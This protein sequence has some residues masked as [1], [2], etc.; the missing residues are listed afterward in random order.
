MPVP[1]ADDAYLWL[2]VTNRH[3]AEGKGGRVA[4][5]WGFR[6][7]TIMTWCKTKMGLGHYLRNATEHVIFGVKGSPGPFNRRNVITH[8]TA[9]SDRHSS[10]PLGFVGVVETLC[11]GPYLELFARRKRKDWTSWGEAVGDPL[12]IGF[13]PKGWSA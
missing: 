8:F 9:P 6:P 1:S 7:L 4:T 13:D 11:D 3:L 12:G 10:K 5:A 2:W